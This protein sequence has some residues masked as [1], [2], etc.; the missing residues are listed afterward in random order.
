MT[1][2]EVS[3]DPFVEHLRRDPLPDAGI[4]IIL[5]TELPL[6]AAENIVARLADMVEALGRPVERTVVVPGDDGLGPALERGLE[7][8]TLPL[9]LVTTAEEPWSKDHLQPLL[10]AIN[11]CDHAIGCRPDWDRGNWTGLPGLLASA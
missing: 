2:I 11:Q 5:L 6:D 7:G 4:R 9:V 1:T 10:D 3:D 8:A